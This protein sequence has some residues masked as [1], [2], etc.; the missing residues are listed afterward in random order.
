MEVMNMNPKGVDAYSRLILDEINTNY[1]HPSPNYLNQSG[2]KNFVDYSSG[3]D[4]DMGSTYQKAIEDQHVSAI[5]FAIMVGIE[6]SILTYFE[7][8]EAKNNVKLCPHEMEPLFRSFQSGGGFANKLMSHVKQQANSKKNQIIGQVKNKIVTKAEQLRRK[9]DEIN[10]M[11]EPNTANTISYDEEGIPIAQPV[12]QPLNF[13]V[14]Q[15]A[16]S[17]KNQI[18]GQVKNKIATKAEQLMRKYNEINAMPEPNTANTISYD[19]EGIPIA[20]PV[21]QPLNF[22]MPKM[23]SLPQ[24]A[25][26]L[27]LKIPDDFNLNIGEARALTEEEKERSIWSFPLNSLDLNLSYAAKAFM[28][29]I[30]QVSDFF[31][32][33]IIDFVTNNVAEKPYDELMPYMKYRTMALASYLEALSKDEEQ[34]EALKDIS[35]SIGSIGEKVLGV[36]SESAERMVG[37]LNATIVNL[38]SQTTEGGMKAATSVA[39]AI[40]GNIPVLGGII[41]LI[42]TMGLIFNNITKIGKEMTSSFGDVLLDGVQSAKKFYEPIRESKSKIL[43]SLQQVFL[44]RYGPEIYKRI[45]K[46]NVNIPSEYTYP[47]GASAPPHEQMYEPPI[48]PNEFVSYNQ[49]GGGKN[50]KLKAKITKHK[51][52]KLIKKINSTRRRLQQSLKRFHYGITGNNIKRFTRRKV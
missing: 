52:R 17:I 2:F 9:Y 19:E 16:N 47:P 33:K 4:F 34:I 12:Q 45:G 44:K 29:R 39:G 27:G 28:K 23:M 49:G 46:M 50:H 8:A 40:I 43:S 20:Q 26:T 10:A 36:F 35:R 32:A 13:N 1:R 24:I 7:K 5:L 18:M 48:Q 37:K 21:Q 42:I 30:L 15:Q 3:N 51:N 31:V 25:K 22:K 38:A 14:K 11:P 6:N 41:N